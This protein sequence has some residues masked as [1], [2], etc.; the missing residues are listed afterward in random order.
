MG[1]IDLPTAL[2]GER[3]RAGFVW[4]R[5]VPDIS[6]V[7]YRAPSPSSDEERGIDEP[8]MAW[9]NGVLERSFIENR[10]YSALSR[11]SISE[12][13]RRNGRGGHSE[14]SLRAG[15]D[16]SR[17]EYF[18][19]NCGCPR[20]PGASAHLVACFAVAA[21]AKGQRRLG[22]VDDARSLGQERVKSDEGAWSDDS[23][24]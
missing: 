17:R 13:E 11:A 15:P 16:S 18:A 6:L 19:P 22:H 1:K 24:E 12:S 23:L 4:M 7:D 8:A 3:L 10:A 20:L 14:A 5:N 2:I 21:L 9:A